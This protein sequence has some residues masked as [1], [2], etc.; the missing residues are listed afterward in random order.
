MNKKII[1]GVVVVLLVGVGAWMV[2]A[3][4]AT[5]KMKAE[6]MMMKEQQKMEAEKKME[7]EKMMKEDTMEKNDAMQKE[8]VMMDDSAM[9]TTAGKYEAYDVSKLAFAKDG[10]VVLFFRASWCPTCRALDA[11]IKE[12][13]KNIPQDVMI[14]D[15]NYDA[16]ADLKTK[17]G[18]TTQHTLVQVDE[19]GNQITKWVGSSSLAELL[20][21][22]K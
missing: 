20:K 4:Q 16:S 11:N 21:N 1:I 15:V 3:Q 6:E 13:M 10:N 12:N 18:V 9:M 2:L 7:S 5:E 14:L 22:V 17:Y 19:N 8:S